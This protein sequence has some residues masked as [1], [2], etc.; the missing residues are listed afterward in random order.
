FDG[1]RAPLRLECTKSESIQEEVALNMSRVRVVSRRRAIALAATPFLASGLAR[2]ADDWPN[3]PARYV[4]VFPPGGPTDTLNRIV[5]A[6]LSE[7]TGQ[8][9]IVENRAGSGG[10]LGTDVIA[11]STPD[12]YTIGLY[13]IASQSIAP[14]LYGKLSFDVQKDFTAIAMLW[15]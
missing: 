3:K 2:A 11:K 7:M 15:S 8:Q 12:G 1:M 9:F 13:T 10:N 5:C 4:N 6:E 14:T